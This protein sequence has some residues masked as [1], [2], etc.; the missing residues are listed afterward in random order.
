VRGW[1]VYAAV[2]LLAAA[3]LMLNA[4]PMWTSVTLKKREEEKAAKAKAKGK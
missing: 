3:H 1:H 2:A 4:N